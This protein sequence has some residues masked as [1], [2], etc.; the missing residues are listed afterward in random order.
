MTARR[1]CVWCRRPIVIRQTVTG[2][3]RPFDV[4]MQSPA[5]LPESLRWVPQRS[6]GDVVMVLA[7]SVNPFRLSGVRWYATAHQC[8]EFLRRLE[9]RRD[10]QDLGEVA[11]QLVELLLG[12]EPMQEDAS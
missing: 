5:D 12:S 8:A 6:A 10:P 7:S 2:R 9:V 11:D 4:D 1:P 3:P